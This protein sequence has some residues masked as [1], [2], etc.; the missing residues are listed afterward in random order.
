M[1]NIEYENLS[2]EEKMHLAAEYRKVAHE[3]E[4]TFS[5]NPEDAKKESIEEI[6]GRLDAER[7]RLLSQLFGTSG[8]E[9]ENVPRHR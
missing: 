8:N 3:G 5:N 4:F 7:D 1:N 9:K 2:E 6:E